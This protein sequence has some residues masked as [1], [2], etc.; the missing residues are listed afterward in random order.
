[1]DN[2][3]LF[4]EEIETIREISD[5][6]M[7]T[8]HEVLDCTRKVVGSMGNGISPVAV[9][10]VIEGAVGNLVYNADEKPLTVEEAVDR[11]IQNLH[12]LDEMEEMFDAEDTIGVLS[13]EI[14]TG[15]V[16]Q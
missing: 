7:D 4:E 12:L 14:D 5:L 2:V 1:M 16:R 11:T 9:V 6:D 13:D 3:E 15:K 8:F 10:D